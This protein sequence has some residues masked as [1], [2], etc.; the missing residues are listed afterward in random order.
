[1][2]EAL[3]GTEYDLSGIT[4]YA[5]KIKINRER[6]GILYRERLYHT[7]WTEEGHTT[8]DNRIS[9]SETTIVSYYAGSGFRVH[10]MKMES[11]ASLV[12]DDYLEAFDGQIYL[13]NYK[14]ARYDPVKEDKK[15]SREELRPYLMDGNAV[16]V[17][18]VQN[19]HSGW[20]YGIVLPYLSMTGRR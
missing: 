19:N 7:A 10:N 2:G 9:Y 16:R 4:L 3:S 8:D 13:Y 12:A 15:W 11:R 5:Q 18:Y 14:T 17:K 1:M 20:E 6:D